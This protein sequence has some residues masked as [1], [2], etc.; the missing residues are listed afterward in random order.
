MEPGFYRAASLDELEDGRSAAVEVG[1][2]PLML[3]R[4]GAQVFATGV[5]C[6]H[7]EVRLD[8]AN[9]FGDE[10]VCKA[11]GYHSNIRTGECLTDP[12]LRLPTYPVR[13]LEGEVWVKFY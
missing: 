13:V 8:P 4:R 2:M 11:H 6:P 5:F 12:D 1:V 10:I 3:H 9:C 7:A